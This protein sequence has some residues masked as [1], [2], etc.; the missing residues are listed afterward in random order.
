MRVLRSCARWFEVCSAASLD[1]CSRRLCRRL[2]IAECSVRLL[3]ELRPIGIAGAAEHCACCL[4]LLRVNSAYSAQRVSN[5]AASC[6]PH[7]CVTA[8]S[9]R[10]GRTTVLRGKSGISRF[11]A[12]V[13][14][15]RSPVRPRIAQLFGGRRAPT[16]ETT[17]ERGRSNSAPRDRRRASL[18]PRSR[19]ETIAP[20]DGGTGRMAGSG[21]HGPISSAGGAR[22][23][24]AQSDR[25]R[26]PIRTANELRRRPKSSRRRRRRKQYESPLLDGKLPAEELIP[27]VVAEGSCD[28]GGHARRSAVRRRTSDRLVVGLRRI[29]VSH[30]AGIVRQL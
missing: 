7:S 30:G 19:A 26:T 25:R 5:R 22:F 1:A 9:I 20:H 13:R 28:E 24:R 4:Q 6:S 17:C 18:V 11:T 23:D 27:P 3:A 2:S 14:D 15:R 16:I 21:A 12:S 8:D 10:T 29:A